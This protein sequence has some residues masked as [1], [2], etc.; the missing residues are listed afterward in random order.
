MVFANSGSEWTEEADCDISGQQGVAA[1]FGPALSV[2]E[3]RCLVSGVVSAKENLIRFV[4]GPDKAVVPDV[5]CKL[6][7][8]GL[9]VSAN[10]QMLEE[11]VGKKLFS[12]A[13]KMQTVV[14]AD[15]CAQVE[16]LLHKRCLSL[17]GLAKSAGLIVAGQAQLEEEIPKKNL[18]YIL[19]AVD[20][21]RDGVKKLCQATLIKTGFTRYE[22]G[23][24][25]GRD[26]LVYI[27]LSGHKLTTKLKAEIIRWQGVRGDEAGFDLTFN[28]IASGQ[29]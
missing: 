8:K 21:G 14:P 28:S 15:L 26:Q 13:A 6:P 2:S 20:C 9:W 12:R 24:A 23:A 5:A 7:G 27:G 22:L 18:S 10:K 1:A 16:L 19:V 17:L 29:P 3:R 11:A 4:V 25:L